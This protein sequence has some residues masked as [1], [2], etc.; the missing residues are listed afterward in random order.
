VDDDAGGLGDE[1]GD[2]GVGRGVGCAGHDDGSRR[3]DRRLPGV[4]QEGPDE[5]VSMD[6]YVAWR[7]KRLSTN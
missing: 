7:L 6:R 5:F 1:V 2:L 3:D 4:V